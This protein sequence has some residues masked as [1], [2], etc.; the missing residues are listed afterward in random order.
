MAQVNET[1]LYINLKTLEENF[2]FLRNKLAAQNKIIAVV[3][4]FAYGLGDVEISKKLETLGV[5]SFWVAD[6]EEGISLRKSGIKKPIIVANPGA[7]SLDLIFKYQLEP[8]IYNHRLLDLYIK[9]NKEIAIHLKFNTGMN[10]FGFDK[11]DISPAIGKIKQ[12]P[13]I[14]V[15]SIC[16]HLSSSNEKQKDEFSQ[17]QSKRLKEISEYVNQ[18]L[19]TIVPTH[20]LN[21]NGV[22][23]FDNNNKDWVRLGIALYGGL[24]QKGLKQ[25]FSLK[26]V[27]SQVRMIHKNESVG[28]QNMFIADRE[29]KIAVIPVGYADGLNRKLGNNKGQVII[30]N[31]PCSIIGN[32]SMDSFI[33]DISNVNAEEGTEVII[34]SPKYSVSQ[35]AKDLDTIPYE[36]M[37]TLNRRIKR[38]YLNE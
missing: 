30:N 28:Y 20:I 32:I 27:I 17:K 7:I 6:F 11:N 4:A 9:S 33:A 2:K 24:E 12:N 34:F 5:H 22:I 21:S 29:M 14:K 35:L 23:R 19:N 38:V 16:S 8:M 36:I 26:S 3:K 13:K 18:Q 37:A 1:I 31:T 15:K 25:I 10:R